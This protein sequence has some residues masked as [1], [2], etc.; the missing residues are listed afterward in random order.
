MEE[1]I[2]ERTAAVNMVVGIPYPTPIKLDTAGSAVFVARVQADAMRNIVVPIIE[3]LSKQ[4]T[5]K[6]GEI[7]DALRSEAD[8]LE[9]KANPSP[10]KD[11]MT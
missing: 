6:W 2:A 1:T 8:A 10:S 9:A 3:E 11:N 7:I 4:P 5:T